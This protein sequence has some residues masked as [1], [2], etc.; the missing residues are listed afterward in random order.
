MIATIGTG[1][2]SDILITM[3]VALTAAG[4]PVEDIG[5]VVA[6]DWFL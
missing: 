2:P 1:L 3:S 6:V 4:L 5:V